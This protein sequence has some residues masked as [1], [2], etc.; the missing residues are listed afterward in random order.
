LAEAVVSS[1]GQFFPHV[2]PFPLGCLVTFS[3]APCF[4]A[5][6]VDMKD[7]GWLV[8]RDSLFDVCRRFHGELSVSSMQ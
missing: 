7:L 4:C 3:Q 2:F 6:I 8:G 1:L 5:F